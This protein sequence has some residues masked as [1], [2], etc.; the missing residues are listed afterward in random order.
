MAPVLRFCEQCGRLYADLV[1]L[2]T[3]LS[4]AALPGRPRD[5]ML[6]PSDAERLRSG[7][8]RTWW[9]AIGS[10]RDRVTRPLAIGFSTLGLAGLLLTAAPSLVPGLG[11][12]AAPVQEDVRIGAAP[13]SAPLI[14]ASQ[15][16]GGSVGG[17]TAT[18]RSMTPVVSAGLI[19]AGMGLF[20]A[21]RIAARRRQ[22][23]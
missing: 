6:D 16:P 15:A 19:V 21:R 9:S 2:S 14:D 4:L 5:Y 3:A 23:R 17:L 20:A 1:A 7:G 18:D 10:A 8:W 12:A 22:V 11:S 13:G